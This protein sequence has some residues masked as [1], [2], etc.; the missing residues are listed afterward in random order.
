MKFCTLALATALFAPVNSQTVTNGNFTF[1]GSYA[2]PSNLTLGNYLGGGSI[3]GNTLKLIVEAERSAAYLA[4]VPILRDCKL[5]ILT[6]V[7]LLFYDAD[8]N[9]ISQKFALLLQ[10]HSY[11][12]KDHW[13]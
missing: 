10:Q 13:V 5:L 4:S 9:I 2:I 11:Y 3:V 7:I 12:R 1:V 8:N 6:F